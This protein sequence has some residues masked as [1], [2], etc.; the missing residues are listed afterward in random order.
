MKIDH[1]Y[2]EDCLETMKRMPDNY[3]DIVV[4]SPPYDNL[5]TYKDNIHKTWNES[6]W[7]AILKELSRVVKFGGVIVWVVNDAT[8]KGSETGTSFKQ[9]LYAIECGLRLHDTMI[10]EKTG[11]PFPS[12]VRYNGVFEYMFVFSKGKPKTFNPLKKPNK[13][14]GQYRRNRTF[15]QKDGGFSEGKELSVSEEGNRNNIWVITN[16]FNSSKDKCAF[17]HPAIFP[18]SLAHDH[19]ISWSNEGD[20]VYD[21][22]LGSGTTAKVAKDLNRNFIG[23]ELSKE[24]CEI[25][26]AR[27]KHWEAERKSRLL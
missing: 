13:T 17:E 27:I 3:I 5:R 9:A 25:A 24:Y 1:I 11:T 18:E 8:I 6:V 4:T 20:L 14:A 19:I 21:P 22:F 10:W 7:K 16:G 2:N 15:R 26:E 23:S 12:Q